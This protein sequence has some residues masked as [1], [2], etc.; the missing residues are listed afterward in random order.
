MSVHISLL[1]SVSKLDRN[2][3]WTR[4]SYHSG[5]IFQTPLLFYPKVPLCSFCTTNPTN[6]SSI[7]VVDPNMWSIL[8]LSYTMIRVCIARLISLIRPENL[9]QISKFFCSSQKQI[10]NRFCCIYPFKLGNRLLCFIPFK[11]YYYNFKW[12]RDKMAY[13]LLQ[14]ICLY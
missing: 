9:F 10:N 8:E 2:Y 13:G 12:I 14:C 4:S 6:F 7:L 5:L 1:L 3:C 11:I